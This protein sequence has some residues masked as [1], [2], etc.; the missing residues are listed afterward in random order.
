MQPVE[1]DLSRFK[2][3]IPVEMLGLT[4]FP[5]IG[6]LPYFLTLPG[7]AFYWF[8]LQQA[9]AADRRARRAGDRPATSPQAPALFMGAAWDT[10]L[11]GNVRTL[12]ERD[13]L[14]AF[15]QRQR[16]FGGKARPMR[17][18]R[19]VD[20][21]LLRRAPQPLFLTIVEVE[22]EDGGRDRYF[23]PLT[24]SAHADV[25]GS[26][27]GRRTRCS[28]RSP[29]PARGSCS[30]PGSTIASRARC[31]RRSSARSR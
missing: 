25:R 3:M 2:G 27:N 4:E 1:L 8:R 15:L 16:W 5:R 29:A 11:E 13:L 28:R 24:I 9:A 7:Y 20:W 17:A 26:R 21:G 14:V 30:T 6:E 22:F 31:S 10:L 19:F 12:I 23:L 18:A